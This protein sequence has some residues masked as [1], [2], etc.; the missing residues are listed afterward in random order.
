MNGGPGRGLLQSALSYELLGQKS[1]PWPVLQ[2][3]VK[4]RY[5]LATWET[6][7]DALWAGESDGIYRVWTTPKGTKRVAM[8]RR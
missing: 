3:R 1:L 2:D 8:V 7:A 5:A 6:I 4:R